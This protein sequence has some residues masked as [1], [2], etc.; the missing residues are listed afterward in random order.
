LPTDSQTDFDGIIVRLRDP[1]ESAMFPG[2]VNEALR[3][4][5]SRPKGRALLDGIVAN[6]GKKKFGYTVCIMRPSG[7][8]FVNDG[9]G[10][11]WSSGSICKRT[12]EI[13]ACNGIGCVS[14]ITWNA[15][16]IVTPDGARPS[17]IGL[18]HE[19]IHAYYSLLGDGTMNTKA[20]EYSTVGLASHQS[21]R[22]FTE[23]AIREEHGLP[24]RMTYIGL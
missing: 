6:A 20:E 16:V 9:S 5:H 21:T 23:N 8:A 14:A 19:L 4:I 7:L 2:I 18:A 11:H 24:I 3:T 12:N 1:G 22:E 13:S 10:P 17:F 15:N